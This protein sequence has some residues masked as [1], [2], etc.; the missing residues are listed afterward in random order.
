MRFDEVNIVSTQGLACEA[1]EDCLMKNLLELTW[2]KIVQVKTLCQ[3]EDGWVIRSWSLV[4]F[5]CW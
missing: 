4:G 5:V 1:D 3:H 2:T